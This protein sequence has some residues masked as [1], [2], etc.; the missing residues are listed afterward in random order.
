MKVYESEI[1]IPLKRRPDLKPWFI[2]LCISLPV[3]IGQF[4]YW[5]IWEHGMAASAGDIESSV[6]A[7]VFMLVTWGVLLTLCL[8]QMRAPLPYIRI[9]H[10]GIFASEGS[11]LIR[12]TDIKE[13]SPPTRRRSHFLRIVVRDIR[14]VNSRANILSRTFLLAGIDERTLPVSMDELLTT[15][16]ERFA[17]ELREHS[18]TIGR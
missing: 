2:L 1:V 14:E 17:T 10:E 6:F 9:N 8:R 11:F 18:I 13:L 16:Q 4:I 15:I 3:M 7:F 12:W 5:A